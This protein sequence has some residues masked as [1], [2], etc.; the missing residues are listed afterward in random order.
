MV[1][2][3]CETCDFASTIK[4]HY[5]RHLQTK[6]HQRNVSIH[7]SDTEIDTTNAK[8][9]EQFSCEYC[10]KSFASRQ[11]KHK[12]MKTSC[13]QKR[14]SDNT[15]CSNILKTL[16]RLEKNMST[17]VQNNTINIQQICM[18]QPLSLLNTFYSSNPPLTDIV[19]Y[20][21]MQDVSEKEAELLKKASE[22]ENTDFIAMELNKLV[23]NMNRKFISETCIDGTTCDSVMFLN[24]GSLRKYIAKGQD[25]WMYMSN[26]ESL[27]E[28]ISNIFDRIYIKYNIP[29]HYLKRERTDIIKKIK[30]LNGWNEERDAIVSQLTRQHPPYIQKYN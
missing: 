14:S 24:D 19:K 12:H 1:V 10:T 18:M 22:V 23:K 17:P 28:M 25:G 5:V 20:I 16:E 29:M 13:K 21:G 8:N 3:T 11:S 9:H 30:K 6:K 15:D 7:A 4:A 2:Y 27:D 26:E